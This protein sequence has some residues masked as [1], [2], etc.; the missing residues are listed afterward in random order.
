MAE[1]G[2]VWFTLHGALAFDHL[3]LG[4]HFHRRDPGARHRRRR[5]TGPKVIRATVRAPGPPCACGVTIEQ[6]SSYSE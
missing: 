3:V 5:S 4:P 6:V 1:L 2:T